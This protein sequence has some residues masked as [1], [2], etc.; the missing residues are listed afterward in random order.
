M[1]RRE[2]I[3]DLNSYDEVKQIRQTMCPIY[4]IALALTEKRFSILRARGV[5]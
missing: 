3:F 5:G 4:L 2:L 1:C